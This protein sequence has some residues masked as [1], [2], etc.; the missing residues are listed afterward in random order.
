MSHVLESII[1]QVR[2]LPPDEQ[3]QIRE[4]LNREQHDAER[5]RRFALSRNIRG[6]YAHIIK[7]SSD[8][9]ARE[10]AGETVAEDRRR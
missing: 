8:D 5:A 7:T 10:K 9:Y 3:R 1:E 4:M 6:K 2:A